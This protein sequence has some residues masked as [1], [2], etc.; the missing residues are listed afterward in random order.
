[1]NVVAP[2]WIALEMLAISGG[3]GSFFNV[4][5]QVEAESQSQEAHGGDDE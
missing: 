1:M 5:Y 3:P 2:A 4:L